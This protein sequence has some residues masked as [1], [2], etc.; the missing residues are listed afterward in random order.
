MYGAVHKHVPTLYKLCLP[1]VRLIIHL[2][3]EHQDMFH[4]ILLKLSCLMQK[5]KFN[6][7]QQK[8]DSFSCKT[9]KTLIN[10]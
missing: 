4:H 10:L 6:F 2:K 5:L 9:F 8:L 7:V 1:Q 3:H